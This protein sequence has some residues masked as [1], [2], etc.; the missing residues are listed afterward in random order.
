MDLIDA[1]PRRFLVGRG[2]GSRQGDLHIKTIQGSAKNDSAGR[3]RGVTT[4]AVFASGD[5]GSLELQDHFVAQTRGVRQ[6]AGRAADSG[7]EPFVRINPERN[8]KRQAG[9]D[10]SLLASA[11]SHASRQSGQ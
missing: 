10:Y 5:D 4:E 6:I 3:A 1:L 11:T 9:H 7:G 8:L 2:L